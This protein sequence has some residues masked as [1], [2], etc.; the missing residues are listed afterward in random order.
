MM[1]N[2]P[3]L[4]W[5]LAGIVLFLLEMSMPGFVL[6]FFG[7]GAWITALASWLLPL[8]LNGQILVFIVS[9]LLSLLTLRRFVQSVFAG[10]TESPGDDSALAAEGERVVVI[11]DI[12]PPAEG[13]VKYSGTSWRAVSDAPIH[14]GEVAE[15]VSQDGL[16][17]KVRRADVDL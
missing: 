11:S 1:L 17:M 7:A 16:L 2:T 9:S 14:A 8:S 6:F 4:L 13:K 3:S 12:V 15:I 5:F 10:D